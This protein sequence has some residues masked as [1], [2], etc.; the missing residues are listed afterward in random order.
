M[1]NKSFPITSETRETRECEPLNIPPIVLEIMH[2][3]QTDV[4][5][6]KDYIKFALIFNLAVMIIF[7]ICLVV[8]LCITVN[9]F[10]ELIQLD[11]T[12]IFI[13]LQ[14]V[15]TLSNL[16]MYSYFSLLNY[17]CFYILYDICQYLSIGSLI[18]NLTLHSQVNSSIYFE[19]NVF[20]SFGIT[21]VV[22]NFFT[23]FFKNDGNFFDTNFSYNSVERK[24][25][26]I[27]NYKEET[28]ENIEYVEIL[29]VG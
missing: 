29:I 22:I 17:K 26:P 12:I 3:K 18:Y 21:Q 11:V 10:I 25:A 27:Y 16:L 20:L 9:K 14:I 7:L 15:F 1:S 5:L 23:L 19:H 6:R 24:Y 13:S 4:H 28:Q 2:K 8:R